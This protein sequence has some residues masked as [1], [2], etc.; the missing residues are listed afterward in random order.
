M[1]VLLVATYTLE[2][3]KYIMQLRIGAYMHKLKLAA[4]S[5]TQP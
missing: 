1:W 3:G 2:Y 4:D 5:M